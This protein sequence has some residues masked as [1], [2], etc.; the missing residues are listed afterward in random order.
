MGSAVLSHYRS[1]RYETLV[2][3]FMAAT[4]S[5]ELAE[6]ILSDNPARIYGFE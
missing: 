4:G 2:D 6:R 3:K 5:A 1:L